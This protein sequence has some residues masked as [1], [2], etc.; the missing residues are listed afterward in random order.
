MNG[1][2]PARTKAAVAKPP[3]G[4]AVVAGPSLAGLMRAELERN[5]AGLKAKG[6][7]A[8]Y[9]IS[10]LAMEEE[11]ESLSSTLGSLNGSGRS[12][13]RVVDVSVRVGSPAFDNHRVIG[14]ERS[15][16]TASGPLPVEDDALAVKQ[17]LWRQTDRAWRAAAQRFIQLK[18]RSQVNQEGKDL[19]EFTEEAPVQGSD[20]APKSRLN[21]A[22][23]GPR[24]KKLSSKFSEYP[25]VISSGLDLGYR[26][27]RRT[28][29]NTE[30][31]EVD[32]GRG[33]TRLTIVARA[34]AMDG[35]DL[36]AT[37]S[38]EATE[39]GKLPP[40][41]TILEAVERVAKNV[42]AQLVAPPVDPFVGPALLSGRAAGVFFHEIF[43]HRVEGHRQRDEQEGQT[44]ANSVG[45]AVLPD[46]LS[47]VFDPTVK[48]AGGVDLHGT[49]SF[50]DEGVKAQPVTVV[51]KGVLKT[52][53]MSRMPLPGFAKSNGHGRKQPGLEAL[54]RQSNLIVQSAKRMSE[55]EL[56]QML[57][58]EIRRQNKPY[59]LYFEQVTGGYT[60]TQR[61]G[62]QAFTV[63]PLVVWRV[64]PDG[65]PDELVRGVDIVGT[66]LASFAKIL[67]T[68]DRDEVF[69]GFCGAESGS[70]PVSAVSPAVLVSE[71]EV[72]RKPNP[73]DR[74]PFL[75]RPTQLSGQAAGVRE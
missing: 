47:V 14:G 75:R 70:V 60:T 57:M 38:F 39:P 44:F 49:Y 29:V 74:P 2:T 8:P 24:L 36:L 71:I 20:L 37:E 50:D 43:G 26:Y 11:G 25:S 5:F 63:V 19:P 42:T 64:Y 52:F 73:G 51:D 23:W 12:H 22:E 6:N 4:T 32:H 65:K 46:F 16:F 18:A 33:F 40:D 28:Y 30:G 1:Q 55:K 72:Q 48:A 35:Q 69:N 45:K 9:F 13:R 59:G 61:G 56:R 62:L 58:E 15:R 68:G 66:P 34:K 3:A 7:P 53:L 67:A 41:K 31:A 21:S 27:E 10:Y 17:Q 54:A